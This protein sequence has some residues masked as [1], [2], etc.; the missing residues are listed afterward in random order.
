MIVAGL[1]G[2]VGTGKST[3]NDSFGESGAM[4]ELNVPILLSIVMDCLKK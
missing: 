3:V 4:K 2:S 1:T